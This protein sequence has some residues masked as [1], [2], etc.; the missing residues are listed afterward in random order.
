MVETNKKIRSELKRKDL[1][2]LKTLAK[3]A[4]M[5]KY[6]KLN[7]R[8]L[9]DRIIIDVNRKKLE[10]LLYGKRPFLNIRNPLVMG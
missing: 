1:P 10:E 2:E 3:K 9:I 7:K 4:G 6:H 8:Q 5:K